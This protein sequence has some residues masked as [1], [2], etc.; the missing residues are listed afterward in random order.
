M[1]KVNLNRLIDYLHRL[2]KVPE[3]KNKSE[4]LQ[5]VTSIK[6]SKKTRIAARGFKFADN[7]DCFFN[8]KLQCHKRII[9]SSTDDF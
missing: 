9:E 1:F 2:E 5:T 4:T 3:N 7:N 6:N 8:A